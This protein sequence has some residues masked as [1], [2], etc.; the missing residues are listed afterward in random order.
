[1][2]AAIDEIGFERHSFFINLIRIP[3]MWFLGLLPSRVSHKVFISWSKDAREAS[4]WAKT[5]KSLE[6][7]YTFLERQKEGQVS[8]G[9]VFWET[10]LSNA[11][12]IRNRLRLTEKLLKKLII[13][14]SKKGTAVQVL[15]LGSGSGRSLFEAIAEINRKFPMKITLLDRSRKALL[16]SQI[17][18][19]KII[20]GRSQNTFQWVHAKINGFSDF[21]MDS[22]SNI[23][24]MEMVGLLDYFENTEA[25]ELF[26]LIH[27][28]LSFNGI[29]LVSNIIPNIERPFITKGIK[30]CL[31]YRTPAQL[32]DLLVEG[33]F[34][35]EGIK[36]FVEPLGIY[37][38]AV[39]RKI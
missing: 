36:L 18:L 34:S 5:Y 25:V 4:R 2:K 6:V 15:S 9:D 8:L 38:I 31:I 19:G 1:M 35:E 17:L 7:M 24:I 11:R 33:G 22:A 32:K 10:F 28:A 27:Q 3:V 26:Q 13:E 16:F 39:C 12:A 23:D 20:K 29:L 14:N 30:W 21:L 37:A